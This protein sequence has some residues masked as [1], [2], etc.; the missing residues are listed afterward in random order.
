MPI[1]L[2]SLARRL[3]V[4]A[5][6]ALVVGATA[7]TISQLI[8]ERESE[9]IAAVIDIEAARLRSETVE[10]AE[11][12][13]DAIH[14]LASVLERSPQTSEQAWR[15]D[16]SA[17]LAR[18]MQF[19]AIQ[20]VEPSLEARWI[21]PATAR[22]PGSALDPADDDVRLEELRLIEDQP[23]AAISRSYTLK[24]GHRQVMFCAPMFAD[25]RGAGYVVGV[26]RLR[27]LLDTVYQQALAD[28]YT[29]AVYEHPFHVYGGAWL[30][31]GAEVVWARDYDFTLS[32]HTWRV[33]VWP[34]PELLKDM[35]S[36]MPLAVQAFGYAMAVLLG[37]AIFL[38]QGWRER[39]LLTQAATH[40]PAVPEP[41]VAEPGPP[42]A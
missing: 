36:R 38:A 2:G 35:R 25:G 27:D 14:D 20:W 31:G 11:R 8:R 23:E 3:A 29:V 32:S 42:G 19:R 40:E 39:A 10:Q 1:T 34:S 18:G 21:E 9:F 26:L 22:V 33:Q 7:F 17:L 4:P 37:L 28:G 41:P 12:R 5:L 15:R 13:L 16:A 24:N 30:K 6:V